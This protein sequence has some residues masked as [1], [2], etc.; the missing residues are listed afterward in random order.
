MMQTYRTFE[1]FSSRHIR[2][3]G[4]TAS[5]FSVL[6]ALATGPTTSCKALG[7]LAFITKGTLTGIIDR[8]ESKGLVQRRAS[9]QDRRSSL[10]DLTDEGR[11]IFARASSSY[12]AYLQ[13]AFLAIG[14]EEL[15]SIEASFR[16]FRQLLKHTSTH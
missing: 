2:T 4:L 11:V 7:E 1:L 14:A 16:R 6:F 13:R 12:F 5:Q 3:L 10:I 8:L 9:I 15:A